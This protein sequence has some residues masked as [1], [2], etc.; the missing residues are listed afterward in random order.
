M[1]FIGTKWESEYIVGPYIKEIKPN[2]D[3]Q[4]TRLGYDDLYKEVVIKKDP[5]FLE[6]ILIDHV[7]GIGV[8]GDVLT[9]DEKLAFSNLIPTQKAVYATEEN[10]RY[11]KKLIEEKQE[12]GP[13]SALSPITAEK[14]Q[15][16][17]FL[18]T[19]SNTQEWTIEKKHIRL[20]LR[21]QNLMVNEDAIELPATKIH[22]PNVGYEGKDII[23]YI[24]IN[25]NKYE[26][27][28][29]RLM[30]HHLN[31]ELD[32]HWYNKRPREILLDEQVEL[33]KQIPEP[34]VEEILD[35][36]LKLKK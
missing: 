27:I 3:W 26:R 33:S 14:L 19:M 7:S 29:I 4:L 6:V 2:D 34:E 35:L 20:S 9:V 30:L 32:S 25:G 15:Q 36:L 24:T 21:R 1:L 22:G 12:G 28:P 13:S 16:K 8:K 17:I 31:A 10:K 11:Y 5:E 18:L 23:V